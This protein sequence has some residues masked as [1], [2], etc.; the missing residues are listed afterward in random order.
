A[1]R[2]TLTGAPGQGSLQTI[3]QNAVQ[4]SQSVDAMVR[5]STARLEVILRNIEGASGDVRTI[6]SGQEQ[7]VA[8][9]VENIAQ[10]TRDIRDVSASIK[11]V[12]GSREEELK[13]SVGSV[14]ETLDRLRRSA[15]NLEE[16]TNKVKSGQGVAGALLTNERTGQKLTESIED[17]SDFVQRLTRL[18]V[19]VA[20]RSEYLFSQGASKNT[21]AFRLIPKP[22]KYYLL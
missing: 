15:A 2:E 1:L 9:I 22:D 8:Q 4:L 21:L 16:I 5:D 7:R 11:Q 13:G 20:V 14:R 17:L 19:E 10:I 6:T 3:V 12:I 18:Q